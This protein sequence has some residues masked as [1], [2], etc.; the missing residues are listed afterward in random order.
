MLL[1]NSAHILGRERK[2]FFPFLNP[3]PRPAD[4]SK[5]PMT[6]RSP[7]LNLAMLLIL[8]WTVPL[9]HSGDKRTED[10]KKPPARATVLPSDPS[11]YVGSD[12]CKTCHEDLYHN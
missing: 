2:R 8:A 7:L 3:C 10:Q 1:A 11:L 12:T 9:G 6:S 5:D 4:K